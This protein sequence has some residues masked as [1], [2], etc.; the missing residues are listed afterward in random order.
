MY[1]LLLLESPTGTILYKDML[2]QLIEKGFLREG[3][4]RYLEKAFFLPETIA[5]NKNAIPCVVAF[6]G[7]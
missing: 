3:D 6:F 4:R 2:N 7:S 5:G 1:R